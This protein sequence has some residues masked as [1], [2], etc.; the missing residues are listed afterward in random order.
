MKPFRRCARWAAALFLSVTAVILVAPSASAEESVPD[1]SIWVT[2]TE[3]MAQP[4][5][6]SIW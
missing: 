4:L 6:D 2:Q 5:S 1:D 3:P